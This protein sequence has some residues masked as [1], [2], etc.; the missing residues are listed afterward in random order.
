MGDAPTRVST[1]VDYQA[2]GKQLG[3]LNVPHSHDLSAWGAI[4]LPIVVIKNG[5]GPTLLLTGGIHGDEYEGPIALMKLAR[6]LEPGAIRGRLIM[7]PALNLP[8]V[9]AGTRVSPVDQVNM[10]RAFPGDP[11]G[12]P[13]LMIADYVSRYLIPLCDAALDLHAGGKTLCFVPF[14]GMHVLADK[15]LMARTRD[16][17]LAFGAPISLIIEEL[18]TVGMLD[19]AVEDRGKVFLFTEL[20]GG[21]TATAHSVAIA[22]RG[23]RNLMGHMGLIEAAPEP[24]PEPAPTRLMYSPDTSYF[25]VSDDAGILEPLADL[26]AEVAGGQAI[27]EVHDVEKPGAAP[28]VYRAARPGLLIGRHHPGLI[29]P[30]DCLAVIAT[31]YPPE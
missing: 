21:G 4:R 3:V 27:A 13:T 29:K 1:R 31:D 16:A 28:V 5:S 18:D 20:G 23:I 6:R 19:T 15:A 7:L 26:C 10:N 8:A 2:D 14:V 17:L 22:E 24:A 30:G 9:L 11:R 12:T 25:T